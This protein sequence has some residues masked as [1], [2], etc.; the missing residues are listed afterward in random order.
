MSAPALSPYERVSLALTDRF[1]PHCNS[2]L[3]G[4]DPACG[5]RCGHCRL[6]VGAGRA[7]EEPGERPLIG[8]LMANAARR[9]AAE[10]VLPELALSALRRVAETVGCNVKRLR[11]ADYDTAARKDPDHPSVAQVLATFESWK[12]ARAAA[13]QS[14][15]PATSIAPDRRSPPCFLASGRALA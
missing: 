4:L 3:H 8:G 5:S 10:P 2:G 1:C 14:A 6:V 13:D 7:L 9:E 15:T 12:H 11:M